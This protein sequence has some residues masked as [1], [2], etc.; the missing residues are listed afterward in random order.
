[1]A[2]IALLIVLGLVFYLDWG[3]NYRQPSWA[4][5]WLSWLQEKIEPAT[6]W[7]REI[8][9]LI[10]LLLPCVGVVWLTHANSGF[11]SWIL[12]L[13]FSCA[14]LFWCLGPHT[15]EKDLQRYFEDMRD[16]DIEG[17]LLSLDEI[18]HNFDCNEKDE[19][20]RQVSRLILMESQRRYFGVI[21][22]F[23]LLGPAAA[24]AYRLVELYAKEYKDEPKLTLLWH[25]LDW[26]PA[27]AT[28]LLFLLTGDFVAGFYR[29]KDYLYDADAPSAH[30]LADTGVAALG[31]DMGVAETTTVEN[32]QALALVQRTLILYL[33]LA[34]LLAPFSLW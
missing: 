26:L 22:W 31:L 18:K 8:I 29:L 12:S 17:A 34:A 27:R 9:A 20:V 10:A 32:R 21:F 11:L 2:L 16:E 25:W 13:L 33:V 15:L 4:V 3:S 24:L 6:G 30:M 19:L 23:I 28:S 14:V 1:M 5:Q 7:Q